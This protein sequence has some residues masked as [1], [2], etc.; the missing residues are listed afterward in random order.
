MT[1]YNFF[2]NFA[3]TFSRPMPVNDSSTVL[4]GN[5]DA[6]HFHQLY[7][8]YYKALA[9]YA[10]VITGN[11]EVAEDIVQDMFSELWE[12]Q[13]TFSRESA[14][15]AYMFKIVR[16]QSLDYV[17]HREV[18]EA[19]RKK[20]EQFVTVHPMSSEDEFF[21]EEIYRRL[22][23]EI[24]ALPDRQREVFVLA[25]RGKKYKQIA[26]EL[27]ISVET[28]KTQRQRGMDTLRRKLGAEVMVFLLF[29]LE[30]Q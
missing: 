27:K 8:T 19:Y 21:S 13:M 5:R 6:A 28:V 23:E 22:F 15:R 25:M 14:L 17:R 1:D 3:N 2:C 4:L 12:G 20:V 11:T 9:S 29:L 7:N 18:E 24:N 16:H 26:E 10:S 30:A